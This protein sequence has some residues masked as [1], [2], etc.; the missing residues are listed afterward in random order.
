MKGKVL[1]V[2]G[3]Y[4]ALGR[5]VAAVAADRGAS[6]AALDF[7]SAPPDGLAERLGPHALLLGDVDL[8]SGGHYKLSDV[9]ISSDTKSAG[10]RPVETISFTYQK[11]ELTQ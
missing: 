3:G 8:S 11:I 1:A 2:T 10:E 5:V 6:V 9:V 4:G 7:A